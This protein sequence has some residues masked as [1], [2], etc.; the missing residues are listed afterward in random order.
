MDA[1]EKPK[2]YDILFDDLVT[3]TPKEVWN[4]YLAD[5]YSMHEAIREERS[6]A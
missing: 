5:G 2:Y 1:N 6:Q 4:Q 3:Q